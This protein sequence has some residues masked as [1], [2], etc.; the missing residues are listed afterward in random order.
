MENKINMVVPKE[1]DGTP[2]K[3]IIE[4]GKAPE[5]LSPK[6]PEIIKIQ[7]TISAP[8]LWLEKRIDTIEQLK[9]HIVVCRDDMTIKLVIDEKNYYQSVILGSLQSSK[10]VQD[11]GIN[12]GKTWEPE[13]LSMFLKMHRACFVT[14]TENMTLVSLLKNFKAKIVS[15]VEKS[16]E[17]SGSKTD[18]Y[19]QV[20]DS[21]LPK[22][23]KIKIPLFK[24]SSTEEI[25]VETYAD[26]DGR[27]ASLTL[28][29]AG[30]TETID[31]VKNNIIDET[32]NH[33]REVAPDIVI[34]EI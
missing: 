34:I 31:N 6:E 28:I 5:E 14:K 13:K 27:N 21:N 11:F 17:E 26:I 19:S 22:S 20:V 9:A 1:Y 33:I 18:N 16:K 30:A 23:F 32:L 10:E 25:E 29:S 15:D 24:G 12:T 8:L 4:E 2:I 7:G 3:V